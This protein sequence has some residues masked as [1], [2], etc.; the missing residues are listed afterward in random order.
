MAL[1]DEELRQLA[2]LEA[3]LLADDP[4]L[5]HR[6]RGPGPRSLPFGRM[7]ASAL[8]LVVGLAMLVAG[9]QGNV[10]FSVLGFLLMLAACALA[11]GGGRSASSSGRGGRARQRQGLHG[12]GRHGTGRRRTGQSP[13]ASSLHTRRSG[14]E[15]EFMDR[16]EDRWRRRQHGD[17]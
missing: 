7:M 13:G 4:Q 1:T 12:T 16:V 5:A 15:G 3:S 17:L 2:Q 9:L 10:L 14:G 6:L 11:I 8:G